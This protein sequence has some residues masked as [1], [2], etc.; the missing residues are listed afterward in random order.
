MDCF[1]VEHIT[2]PLPWLATWN[3]YL[4]LLYNGQNLIDFCPCTF[5]D[6]KTLWW[7]LFKRRWAIVYLCVRWDVACSRCTRCR[8]YRALCCAT[9]KLMHLYDAQRVSQK[10]VLIEQNHNQNWVPWG[11][12]LPWTWLG[13][14]WSSLILVRNDQKINFWTHGVPVTSD[15][16][17]ALWLQQHSE[18]AFLGHP[19]VRLFDRFDPFYQMMSDK[20][21]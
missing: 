14:A 20:F 8:R 16:A 10:N 4:T 5:M 9:I 7:S 12:I 15:W 6:Y 11:K 1:R 21:L 19:V 2:Y 13:K 3:I 17:S 18:S